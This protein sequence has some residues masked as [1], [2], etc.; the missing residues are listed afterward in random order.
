VCRTT[1]KIATSATSA[2]PMAPSL[3]SETAPSEVGSNTRPYNASIAGVS[4]TAFAARTRA[5]SVL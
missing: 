1:V 2:A 3:I 4:L 5:S